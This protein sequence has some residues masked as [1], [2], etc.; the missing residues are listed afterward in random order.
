MCEAWGLF[1][2][3]YYTHLE[4]KDAGQRK[5]KAG[6]ISIEKVKGTTVEAPVPF[7]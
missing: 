1:V 4:T 5:R 2:F 7:T 3:G 6:K